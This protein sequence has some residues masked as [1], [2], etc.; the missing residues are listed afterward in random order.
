MIIK[1]TKIT[2]AALLGLSLTACFHIQLNGSVGGGTL[3]IAPLRTPGNVVA[4]V[5]SWTPAD[6]LAIWGQEKWDEHDSLVNL[7]LVGVNPLQPDNLSPN[8]LYVVTASGGQDYDPDVQ[9]ALSDSPVAVQGSW[10][11]I[12]SGKRIMA[13]NLKVSTLTEALYQQLRPRL[14]EWSN[15]EILAR[16]N[17]S[18]TLVVGD[19]DDNGEVNYDDVLRWNRTFDAPFYRGKLSA[20]DALSDA[21]T[22]GQTGSILTNKAKDVLGSQRV[23]LQF[24]AGKVVLKTFNWQSPITAANFLDYVRSGYYNQTLVHRS[25]DGFMIQMGLVAVLGEDEEG[26]V[27]WELKTPNAPIVN[28]SSNGLSNIRGSLSMARTSDPDSASSQFFINQAD[29]IFLD[30]GS[31]NSPDGYAVFARAISGMAV[32]DD[33]AA[34][35]TTSVQSIGKDV[36]SRGVILESARLQ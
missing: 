15:D 31:A 19:V 17:A 32:V 1:F 10:H 14:G 33:I 23:V 5:V 16:L 29:N 27:Q 12:A 2:L 9:R 30:H 13:G 7:A 25:I 28:E 20:I 34:E 35:A 6:L 18:A 26:L 4:T 24:D 21:I 11:M 22:A 36:P 3:T 8:T